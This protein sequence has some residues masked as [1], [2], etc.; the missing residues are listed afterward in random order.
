MAE[1]NTE[2]KIVGTPSHLSWNAGN[3]PDFAY[4]RMWEVWSNHRSKSWK[5][6]TMTKNTK[7]TKRNKKQDQAQS[8]HIR[9]VNPHKRITEDTVEVRSRQ[10]L[11]ARTQ[12]CTSTSQRATSASSSSTVHESWN[13]EELAYCWWGAGQMKILKSSS[14]LTVSF[15]SS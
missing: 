12:V 6:W 2:S 13:S 5:P 10:V 14:S 11:W 1:M 15:F 7:K 4:S 9:C 8:W 3:T